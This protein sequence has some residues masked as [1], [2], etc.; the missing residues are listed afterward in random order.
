MRAS[1]VLKTLAGRR[2][3]RS[4]SST[5][6][7]DL[8]PPQEPSTSSRGDV[9]PS[10]AG[11]A[12]AAGMAAV[13]LRMAPIEPHADLTPTQHAIRPHGDATSL[14]R[15]VPEHRPPPVIAQGGKVATPRSRSA[16]QRR[17]SGASPGAASVTINL[18]RDEFDSSG[19]EA[20]SSFDSSP[21]NPDVDSHTPAAMAPGDGQRNSGRTPPIRQTGKRHSLTPRPG[22]APASAGRGDDDA[23]EVTASHAPP[24]ATPP[25]ADPVPVGASA[26]PGGAPSD[27][28]SPAPSEP[29]SL[30]GWSDATAA[31]AT[32]AEAQLEL[33][34]SALTSRLAHLRR[35]SDARAAALGLSPSGRGSGNA[36]EGGPRAAW[37]G[38]SPEQRRKRIA[39][40]RA[41]NE[42]YGR[43]AVEVGRRRHLDQERR[44][45]HASPATFG[46]TPKPKQTPA[47]PRPVPTKRAVSVGA[48][49]SRTRRRSELRLARKRGGGSGLG[50]RLVS[51]ASAS[52]APAKSAAISRGGA[53]KNQQRWR[54][55]KTAAMA[56]TPLQEQRETKTS[57][58]RRASVFAL[59]GGDPLAGWAVPTA[60]ASTAPEPTAAFASSA[61]PTTPSSAGAAASGASSVSVRLDDILHTSATPMASPTPLGPKAT[62]Q[63]SQGGA[64][65]AET[66]RPPWGSPMGSKGATQAQ[67][68]LPQQNGVGGSAQAE[69]VEVSL[70]TML[71]EAEALAKAVN[72]VK[73]GEQWTPQA[74]PEGPSGTAAETGGASL[75]KRNLFESFGAA[76]TTGTGGKGGRASDGD[77]SPAAAS[78]GRPQHRRTISDPAVL[79]FGAGHRGH[80][81]DAPAAPPRRED[82]G[83]ETPGPPTPA[84]VPTP[85]PSAAGAG[86]AASPEAGP[87][88]VGGDGSP[89]A[90][91]ILEPSE[92]SLLDDAEIRVEEQA[93]PS[94]APSYTA[95]AGASGVPGQEKGLEAF[96]RDVQEQYETRRKA[97]EE[98]R[99]KMP[100]FTWLCVTCCGLMRH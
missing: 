19:D 26:P 72:L 1:S 94:H 96:Y 73:H 10:P 65:G 46:G 92:S 17:R 36:K 31:M 40:Q 29:T 76:H 71:A 58:T 27:V 77:E 83:E 22:S 63:A 39:E 93:G 33:E 7:P 12:A 5:D 13:S 75:G 87:A 68:G 34:L 44:G 91:L 28:P 55:A 14:D 20:S 42:A 81:R 48:P 9:T 2:R 15:P 43:A 61:F 4:R 82:G 80:A 50:A 79:S 41:R 62:K 24:A 56:R 16:P 8:S 53:D 30:V 90:G 99:R 32:D 25:D 38:E 86:V 78:V 45:R 85:G 23:E 6:F 57:K 52:L 97:G 21:S 66:K 54:K 98:K 70:Q 18:A 3:S 69:E 37:H 35:I 11:K 59:L 100:L 88:S 67:G 95:E 51:P 49:G 84:L 74:V 47:R 64:L 89:V 60:S